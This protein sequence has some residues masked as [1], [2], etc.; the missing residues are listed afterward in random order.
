MIC[1]DPYFGIWP[2]SALSQ[3]APLYVFCCLFS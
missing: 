3:F 1:G 2:V